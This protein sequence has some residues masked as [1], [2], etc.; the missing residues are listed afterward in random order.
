MQASNKPSGSTARIS[1]IAR[2]A[3]EG[4]TRESV[5]PVEGTSDSGFKT[6]DA[7]SIITMS[8]S[9]FF[10][11]RADAFINQRRPSSHSRVSRIGLAQIGWTLV[12]ADIDYQHAT[13]RDNPPRSCDRID[14]LH[15]C[16]WI[17][18]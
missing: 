4:T 2:D 5:A 14:T 9:S 8:A 18:P 6:S 12:F 7:A 13:D 16:E 15:R 3:K 11:A 10:I 1:R 17:Q